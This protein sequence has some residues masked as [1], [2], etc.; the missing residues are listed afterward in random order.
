MPSK[1]YCH[2][3]QKTLIPAD[4]SA[5]RRLLTSTVAAT[6]I[7]PDANMSPSPI[8][9]SGG[10]TLSFCNSFL[11][12]TMMRRSYR[13]TKTSMIVSGIAASEAEEIWKLWKSVRSIILPWWTEKVCSWAR[14]QF[15]MMVLA[16]MGSRRR[17]ALVS[18]TW[19]LFKPLF[20]MALSKNLFIDMSLCYWQ[21]IQMC[22]PRNFISWISV[23]R[24]KGCISKVCCCDPLLIWLPKEFLTF[25]YRLYHSDTRPKHIWIQIGSWFLAPAQPEQ[26]VPNPNA[27]SHYI[28][29]VGSMF[30]QIAL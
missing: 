25:L 14:Q 24:S 15:I 16:K 30:G 19:A 2:P 8:R 12:K 17:N 1:K 27:G 6:T 7:D 20:S 22:Y 9:W 11:R 28:R 26:K 5:A 18:S 10:N 29:S 13:G 21:S 3:S 4:S 23:T